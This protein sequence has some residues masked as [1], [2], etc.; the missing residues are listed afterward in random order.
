MSEEINLTVAEWSHIQELDYEQIPFK[1]RFCH[2]YG[3]FAR[4]CK[5]KTE[6][7]LENEKPWQIQIQKSGLPNQDNRKNGKYGK[8]KN[9]VQVDGKSPNVQV[10]KNPNISSNKFVVLSSNEE[11]ANLEEG[12]L[13][14]AEEQNYE[15]EANPSLMFSTRDVYIE[16]PRDG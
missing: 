16:L 13:Q 6:N 9:G 12:E 15:D 3:H 11:S 2:G 5:K 4:N 7:D 10:A 14:H 1:C 8:V